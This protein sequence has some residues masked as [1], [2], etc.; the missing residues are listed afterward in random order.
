MGI[1]RFLQ[2]QSIHKSATVRRFAIQIQTVKTEHL[3]FTFIITVV[4]ENVGRKS[5]HHS[6][7]TIHKKQ[8]PC[9][10]KMPFSG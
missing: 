7:I 6:L 1:I 4:I 10:T 8:K 2:I 5:N 9:V 3:L